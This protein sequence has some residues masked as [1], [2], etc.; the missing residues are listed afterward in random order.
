MRTHNRIFTVLLLGASVLAALSGEAIAADVSASG[1]EDSAMEERFEKSEDVVTRQQDEDRAQR[2]EVKAD[3][4]DDQA[5]FDLFD[6]ALGVLRETSFHG[7][8]N[9]AYGDTNHRNDYTVG[10]TDGS[11][12]NFTGGLNFSAQP[13]EQLRVQGQIEAHQDEVEFEWMFAEWYFDE[14]LQAR[15]GRSKHPF[16]IYSEIH[17][18][19]TLRPFFTVPTSVYGPNGISAE[20][21]DGIGFTGRYDFAA[22]WGLAYDLYG[23]QISLEEESPLAVL[24]EDDEEEMGHG[25]HKAKNVIGGRLVLQTPIEGLSVGSSAYWGQVRTHEASHDHLV[26]GFQGEYLTDDISIRTEY[27]HHTE[28]DDL[29]VDAV[30]VE[31]AYR[32]FE[33]FQL[34]GRWEWSDDDADGSGGLPSSLKEHQEVAVGLN[35]WF[36]PNFVMKTSYHHIWGNRFAFPSEDRL[37]TTI[38]SGLLRDKT[39]MVVA[40]L[41]FSF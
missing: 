9:W 8:G 1:S 27:Y 11:Y 31:A 33:K 24:E 3:S 40:G 20:S 4:H 15:V 37:T 34:A 36:T 12:D 14:M 23:G 35:Y 16:G 38:E 2:D 39:D 17:D 22:S 19:G 32:F 21:Y 28:G 30:Y 18:I 26:W 29:T 10:E 25:G 41:Q 5:D 7:F 6:A 13:H